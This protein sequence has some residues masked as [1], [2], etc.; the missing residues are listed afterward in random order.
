ML[1]SKFLE[2]ART[3]TPHE[4]KEFRSYVRSPFH[5]TNKN[6]IKAAEY[7]RRYYPE[8]DSS[9]LS[10]EN[11]FKILYPGKKYNDTVMRILLSDLLRLAEEFLA[12]LNFNRDALNEKK[13]LLAELEK[14]NLNSLFNRHIK[15]ARKLVAD[16]NLIDISYFKDLFELETLEVNNLISTG[17]Q[18]ESANNVLM[19]GKHLINFFIASI[20]N[21][22]HEL[23]TQ[24]EVLNV[25][26]KFNPVKEFLQNF[27]S[28][29]FLESLS[30]NEREYSDVLRIYYLMFLS[31]K[32]DLK[33]ETFVELKNL[34][35]KNLHLFRREEKFNLYIVLESFCLTKIS[36]GN[37][38]FFEHL[39]DIYDEM[40][41]AGIY[42]HSDN[43]CF[44]LNLFRNMFYTAN[45]LKRFE[46]VERF[47]SEH[48]NELS[49]EYRE[50]TGHLA[51]A[52]LSFEKGDFEKALAEITQVEYNYFVFKF[53]VRLLT[54]KIYYELHSFE[55]ALSLIDTFSHFLLNNKSA[56][57]YRESFGEFLRI[58][59]NMIKIKTGGSKITTSELTMQVEN[60]KKLYS[61][62]WLLE[63]LSLLK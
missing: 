18:S 27:D 23:E 24:H 9:L 10:K 63:K 59:K 5:N 11:I 25:N 2:I 1:N 58:L 17:K 53:D 16:N 37:Q 56:V 28:G 32:E 35:H 31:G 22:A 51:Y 6:V 36:N 48:L 40:L 12:L 8:F 54:L 26:F 43:E 46:W 47:I 42:I 61:K 14:R 38:E 30:E 49:P 41:G 55:S 4:M 39:M 19:Q 62:M 50:N 21:I 57:H 7:I 52:Y 45:K 34:V 13:F 60:S 3:F 20:F 33:P 44:Q 15:D 29:K